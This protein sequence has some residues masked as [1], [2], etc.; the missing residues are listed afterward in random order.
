MKNNGVSFP[1][2]V[3]GVGDDILPRPL[4]TAAKTDDIRNYNFRF[5]FTVENETIKNLISSGKALPDEIRFFIVSF[6]TVNSNRKL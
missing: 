4:V 1:H 2:P 3:M 6:S 5:E